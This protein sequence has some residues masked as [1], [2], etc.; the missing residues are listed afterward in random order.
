M[1]CSVYGLKLTT[2]ILQEQPTTDCTDKPSNVSVAQ[3]TTLTTTTSDASECIQL[4]NEIL[5]LI[6]AECE[7]FEYT[8]RGRT[9]RACSRAS[10]QLREIVLPYLFSIIRVTAPIFKK[11][12]PMSRYIEFTK[13]TPWIARH[14]REVTVAATTVL[15]AELAALLD[16]LPCLEHVG[17]TPLDIVP[18]DVTIGTEHPR[19]TS[20]LLIDISHL[21]ELEAIDVFGLCAEI[22]K[23]FAKV[24]VL[25]IRDGTI[26]GRTRPPIDGSHAQTMKDV[27][28]AAGTLGENWELDGAVLG[29]GATPFLTTLLGSGA[30]SHITFLNCTVLSSDLDPL[31]KILCNLGP[32]LS[33]LHLKA[34]IGPQAIGT[35]NTGTGS[36][37]RSHCDC[38]SYLPYRNSLSWPCLHE[39]E[40]FQSRLRSA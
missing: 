37:P 4:P 35:N 8:A 28:A 20:N 40:E 5:H 34:A 22:F 17:L 38:R 2:P 9:L 6:V 29:W 11:T 12:K 23:L 32:S 7:N 26:M 19:S 30:L 39:S 25:R 36:F 3:A 21:C 33:S 16:Q 10:W 18:S 13:A 31:G 14:V 1:A 15:I 24:D 27:A